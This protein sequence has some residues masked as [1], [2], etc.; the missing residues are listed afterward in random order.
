MAKPTLVKMSAKS[1]Q[2]RA[3]K[4]SAAM[5]PAIIVENCSLEDDDFVSVDVFGHRYY[6]PPRGSGTHPQTGEYREEWGGQLNVSDILGVKTDKSNEENIKETARNPNAPRKHIVRRGYDLAAKI[7]EFRQDRGV[8]QVTGDDELDE[9]QRKAG[10]ERW[11][12]WRR[13]DANKRVALYYA[14]QETVG[15][16]P[17]HLFEPMD[18]L[19]LKSQ[20]F[21]EAFNDSHGPYDRYKGKLEGH[22]LRCR[23]IEGKCG[24]S[25]KSDAAGKAAFLRHL[26]V[27]HKIDEQDARDKYAES[28][29]SADEPKPAKGKRK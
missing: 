20:N 28:F 12:S 5:N 4:A 13:H 3:A 2:E 14:H 24:Y 26:R 9:Q 27:T 6:L 18:D 11:V 19:E 22:A 7:V 17:G 29:E 25:Q 1:L 15:K 8:F 21:I 10:T 16:N 23:E